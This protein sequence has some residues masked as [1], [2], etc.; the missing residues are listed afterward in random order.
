MLLSLLRQ[1]PGF[2]HMAA[3]LLEPA[4][5]TCRG[6]PVTVIHTPLNKRKDHLGITIILSWGYKYIYI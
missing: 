4:V 1:Q 2:R 3:V 5:T 6:R